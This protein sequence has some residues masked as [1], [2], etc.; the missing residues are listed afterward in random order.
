M[1]LSEKQCEALLLARRRKGLT[2][3]GAAEL[4]GITRPYYS[5]IERGKARL[6]PLLQ[7]KIEQV[8]E[9]KLG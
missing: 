8:L 3:T 2:Q 9:V 5:N 1:P 6:L 4:I 7:A